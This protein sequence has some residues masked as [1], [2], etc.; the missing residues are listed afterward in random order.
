VAFLLSLPVGST[1]SVLTVA[2]TQDT[3]VDVSKPDE[4][5]MNQFDITP[6]EW[7]EIKGIAIRIY[8]SGRCGKDQMKCSIHAFLE[9]ISMQEEEIFI[10]SEMSEAIH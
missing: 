2:D 5:H 8:E 7:I 9:W 10:S 1:D 6:E 4:R 3:I